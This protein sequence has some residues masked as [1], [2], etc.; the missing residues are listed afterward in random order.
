VLQ[1]IHYAQPFERWTYSQLSNATGNISALSYGS[2]CVQACEI[3][4]EDC[5]ILNIWDPLPS[6]RRAGE[7]MAQ[8]G[9]VP[10]LWR[11]TYGW[12]G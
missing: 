9:Q 6:P 10:D 2:Q 12:D 1:G 11:R 3:G 8:T 7:E 4:D 5:L